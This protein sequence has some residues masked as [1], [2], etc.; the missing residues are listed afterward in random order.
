MVSAFFAYA[1]K[2]DRPQGGNGLHNEIDIEFIPSTNKGQWAMQTNYFANHVG[3]REH[4]VPLRFNP[5]EKF[6]NYAFKWTSRGIAWYVDGQEVYRATKGT[7]LE[8][9]STLR[10][11]A[12]LWAV[13]KKAEGWAGKFVYTKELSARYE[14]VRF[15]R[16][17]H[18]R[19]RGFPPQR[20]L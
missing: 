8:K 15:T 12:N 6:H 7:P 19:V 10:I 11:M 13:S 16:G 20:A 5:T 18:C 17:E 1:G 9:D 4:V 3:H 2:Y 14:A